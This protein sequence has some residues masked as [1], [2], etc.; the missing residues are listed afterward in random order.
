M[1]F[2]DK[3]LTTELIELFGVEVL[4]WSYSRIRNELEDATI[5]ALN[6][7]DETKHKALRPHMFAIYAE[8][9]GVDSDFTEL[10]TKYLDMQ[11]NSTTEEVK[12]INNEKDK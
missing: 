9:K 11:E 3:K 6:K 7:L 2:N 10:Y 8:I 5:E 12:I 1:I 4:V